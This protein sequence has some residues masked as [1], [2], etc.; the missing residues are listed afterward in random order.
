MLQISTAAQLSPRPDLELLMLEIDALASLQKQ[1]KDLDRAIE[2]CKAIVNALLSAGAITT[3][4][5]TALGHTATVSPVT[6]TRIDADKARELLHPNT[7]RA[8]QVT[9]TAVRLTVR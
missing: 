9:T 7:L 2:G 3:A 5:P 8:I 1:A 4:G 6:T